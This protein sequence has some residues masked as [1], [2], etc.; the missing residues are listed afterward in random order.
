MHERHEAEAFE[1][2]CGL[3]RRF[4][5][6]GRLVGEVGFARLAEAHV[7]VAG[8]GGVGSFAAE[9]LARSAVGRLTLV[10]FDVVCATNTNRQIEALRP[11][12]GRPKVDAL[13]ERLRLINPDARLT[14]RQ[15]F[16][17]ASTADQILDGR[18][19]FV[20]DAVDNLTTKSH[21]LATCRERGIPVVCSTGASGRLDPTAVVIADLAET[22]VDPVADAV[23][24]I[25]RKKHGFPAK[26]PF[27]IPAVFST[28]EPAK[29]RPFEPGGRGLH[30]TCPSGSNPY[31]S[32]ERRRL[33]YGTASFVTGTLGLACASVVVRTL[34]A[35][36]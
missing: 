21:L 17:S 30:C 33:T 28:E 9:S 4:D 25:L 16:Y 24:R 19:D 1:D 35:G 8:L 34:T 14:S 36:S 13:A 29:P 22:R 31:H 26:G 10:D 18:V 11:T 2:D 7:V 27:G 5:R 6:V 20:V 32:A 12:I 23:R 15:L 3:R